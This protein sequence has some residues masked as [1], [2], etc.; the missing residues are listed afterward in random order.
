MKKE[1]ILLKKLYEYLYPLIQGEV[2][3]TYKDGIPS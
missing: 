3:V 1:M 2:H